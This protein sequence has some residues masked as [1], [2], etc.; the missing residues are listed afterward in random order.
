MLQPNQMAEVFRCSIESGEAIYCSTPM[1]TGLVYAEWR[2]KTD[3]I[4]ADAAY[5]AE[6]RDK[7]LT[8]NVTRAREIVASLRGTLRDPIIDP[9][10]FPQIVGWRRQ[11]YLAMWQQVIRNFAH[12]VVMLPGWQYS[13][14]CCVEYYTALEFDCGL[15]TH[16]GDPIEPGSAVNLIE[17]AVR[18]YDSLG[19]NSAG[20]SSTLDLIRYR[21]GRKL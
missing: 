14:G 21:P 8:V 11:D 16:S 15:T 7:V 5:Y 2:A 18:H 9:T 10:A 20:L 4:E 13:Y 12:T 19:V 1:N 3:L 17:E 6:H